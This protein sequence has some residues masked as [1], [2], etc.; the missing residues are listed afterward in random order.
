MYIFS[1]LIQQIIKKHTQ[2]L[3]EFFLVELKKKNCSKQLIFLES[4]GEFFF[5][6]DSDK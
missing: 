2:F 1:S 6:H 4:E 5:N 3:Y